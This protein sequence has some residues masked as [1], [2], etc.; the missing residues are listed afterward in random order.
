[1]MQVS[2]DTEWLFDNVPPKY[3]PE[4]VDILHCP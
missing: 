3:N 1:M 4:A 2:Y